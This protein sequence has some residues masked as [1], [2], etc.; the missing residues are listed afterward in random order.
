MKTIRAHLFSGFKNPV[1][2]SLVVG[3]VLLAPSAQAAS[4]ESGTVSRDS[5]TVTWN[6]GPFLASNPLSCRTLPATC[7]E[8]KLTIVPPEE[9][10]DEEGFVVTVRITASDLADDL[11]LFVRDPE[12]GTIASSG[13]AGGVEG[14]VLHNPAPGTYTVV[15]QPFLVR[16]TSVGTYAGV[17]AL[18][19]PPEEERAKFYHGARVGPDFNG[20]P[21]SQPAKRRPRGATAVKVNFNYVG[22]QAAEPTIGVNANNTAFFAAATFDSVIGISG[23]TRLAR[24]VVMR[25]RDKGV[26]W[27]AVSPPFL[28][29]DTETTE[30]T[31]TLDPMLHVDPD[32][33]RIFS[34]DLYVGCS[35]AIFS[36]D[37]G[38][39]WTRNPL[40]CG[41]PVNDHHTIVT[42]PPRPGLTVGYPNL[43]YYCFNRVSD[44][45]CGRSHDGGQTF[46][47]A[48][49]AFTG[50]DPDT[51]SFCGGLH[52]HL[53]A[54]RTPDDVR[55]GVIYLPKGHCGLPWVAISEDGAETWRRVKIAGNTPMADHEV[56][57]AFDTA[58]A[59]YAVWADGTFRL[60]FL[61]VSTDRGLT[62]S[63]PLMFAP[64]GVHEVNF[65]TIVAG[66]AG[67]IAVL[68]PGS[69]STDFEDPTRP[70]N[71]YIVMSTNAL[72]ANP[73][74]TWTT[75]NNPPDPVH[76]GNCGPGRCDA[77]D[78][79]SMFDF[80]DIQVSPADGA[81]WGTA[82]DTCVDAC[83]TDP[84]ARKLRPG[85]GVAIRQTK[86]PSLFLS[87]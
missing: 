10:A 39:T 77:Q 51:G 43:V 9:G 68:F 22:R 54:D 17:A 11:D 56:S 49:T 75:A 64:P 12:G 3:T 74:F 69:E 82:S 79:G 71:I 1:V 62:W 29:Q 61:S 33:G 57:L 24:T 8:F 53:A 47:A 37:E 80:L 14:I 41:Q 58:G 5:P 32:T 31:F 46:V 42:A 63:T 44:S 65:P 72:D 48:G 28:L 81:F 2:A 30:P 23:V 55:A 70:W 60:P 4:P 19:V 52:G 15:V 50:F 20:I 6:G 13:T 45:S 36:D 40:A 7:D 27:E 38:V 85:Q 67:R 59:L 84:T 25:S 73:T 87:R 78:G 66:D 35:N 18:A 26:T 76:R 16:S 21:A 34:V 83:V 86:G